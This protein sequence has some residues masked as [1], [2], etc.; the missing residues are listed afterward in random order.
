[1]DFEAP[2]TTQATDFTLPDAAPPAPGSAA[3]RDR[4][5]LGRI[6][7]PWRLKDEWLPRYRLRSRGGRHLLTSDHG[8]WMFVT[9]AELAELRSITLSPGLFD[10]LE[11]KGMILTEA[12]AAEQLARWRTWCTHHYTGT[13]LHILGVTRRCNLKC[14]YCH[15]AVVPESA[16]PARFDM[17]VEVGRRIVDFA[18]QSP[19]THIHFEFQG[20]EATMNPALI[21]DVYHYARA[22]NLGHKRELTFSIVTNLVEL[23]PDLA[24]FLISARIRVATTIELA[25]PGEA[26]AR[27]DAEGAEHRSAVEANRAALREKGLIA[28]ALMVMTRKNL[29]RGRAYIDHAVANG[30]KAIFLSPVQKLGFAKKNWD[31]IGI[32]ADQFLA[33]WQDSLEHMFALWDRG[34]L[35]EERLFAIALQ[36]LFRDHDVRYMDFRNPN[37]TVLGNIAYDQHGNAFACDEGRAQPFFKI[38]NVFDQDFA[39]I[40]TGARARE[41]VSWSLRELPPCQICAYK[42][43]CGVHPIVSHAE[44]GNPVPQPLTDFHC[45]LTQGIFDYLF[46]LAAERPERIAQA[47][48]VHEAIG[49]G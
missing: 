28:P 21:R 18:F 10:R 3:E 32:D 24:D 40:V 1:M 42:P 23:D 30:Q 46:D 5:G 19:S 7:A 33:A 29:H 45:K 8:D 17:P 41:I 6:F 38:G 39:D 2:V 31:E 12:N 22:K 44:T 25:G 35:I 4:A 9:D 11:A 49:N 16:D 37:G 43:Y 14:H 26:P 36:K 13:S 15:A 47:Q 34:V 48:F 27:V 20:G